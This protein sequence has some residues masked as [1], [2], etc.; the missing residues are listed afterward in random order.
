MIDFHMYLCFTGYSDR[1][2]LRSSVGVSI[3]ITLA[4]VGLELG[5][6]LIFGQH[7]IATSHTYIYMGMQV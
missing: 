7:L 3:V 6:K 5:W 2:I 1:F 4:N